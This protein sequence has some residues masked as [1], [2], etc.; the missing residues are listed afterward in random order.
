MLKALR[1]SAFVQIGVL[2]YFAT[3]PIASSEELY[4]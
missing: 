4:S 1:L 2:S 3:A